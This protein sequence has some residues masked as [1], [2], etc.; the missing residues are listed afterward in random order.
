[1]W[2]SQGMNLGPPDYESGKMWIAIII[3]FRVKGLQVEVIAAVEVAV[4][5]GFHDVVLAD[6]DAA[7]EVGNGA[8]DFQDAVISPCTHVHLGDGFAQLLHS[9]GIGLGVLLEQS[10]CHLSVAVHTWM[11]LEAETLDGSCFDD[12]FP[13]CCAR[14]AWLFA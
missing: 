4:A 6:G 3:I 13:Y 9:F 10:C 11:V 5:Y 2:T 14:F 7:F 12:S 8:G 1:M